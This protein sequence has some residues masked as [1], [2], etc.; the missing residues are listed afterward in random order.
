MT[1]LFN[2]RIISR[3]TTKIYIFSD[4]SVMKGQIG[5]ADISSKKVRKNVVKNYSEVERIGLY[6]LSNGSSDDI[7]L[8]ERDL[9][10]VSTENSVHTATREIRSVRRRYLEDIDD[11]L[12]E[13]IQKKHMER[14]N[15]QISHFDGWD[16]TQIGNIYIYI[17]IYKVFLT[18]ESQNI[19]LVIGQGKAFIVHLNSGYEAENEVKKAK[20]HFEHVFGIQLPTYCGRI[21]VSRC[22]QKNFTSARI[23]KLIHL[24]QP[25]ISFLEGNDSGSICIHAE[26]T[27][28]F[29]KEGKLIFCSY[30]PS[31][32]I[33][34]YVDSTYNPYSY[35]FIQNLRRY[36][37]DAPM[38]FPTIQT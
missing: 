11:S 15:E 6:D 36:N 26:E 24:L 7:M 34:L 1:Q 37:L 16:I 12:M 27:N 2:K 10:S 20:S 23:S 5:D 3:A 28:R 4:G 13:Q 38:N 30:F 21:L 31:S 8:Q 18:N 19:Y 17:Y 25:N 22:E 35:F 9:Y 32:L 29:A 33:V 14:S